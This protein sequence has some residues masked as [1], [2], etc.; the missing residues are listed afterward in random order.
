MTV[1][2][3]TIP[4][5]LER[6]RIVVVGQLHSIPARA[7]STRADSPRGRILPTDVHAA[8]STIESECLR[9]E[10]L[11]H[12]MTRK[13]YKSS[14]NDFL[15]NNFGIHHLHLGPAGDARER[16]GGTRCAAGGMSCSSRS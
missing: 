8:M 2:I 13:F 9:G 10:D 6:L 16:R 14:F 3:S 15:F 1:T 7:L 11:T 5:V 4:E 12:R